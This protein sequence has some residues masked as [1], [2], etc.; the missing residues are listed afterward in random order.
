MSPIEKC[1]CHPSNVRI[2]TSSSGVF[3]TTLVDTKKIERLIDDKDTNAK[4]TR[5]EKVRDMHLGVRVGNWC[6]LCDF[7]TGCLSH[8][9]QFMAM[10]NG[11]S[12]CVGHVMCDRAQLYPYLLSRLVIF[13]CVFSREWT[14]SILESSCIQDK[15]HVIF[16][17]IDNMKD[18]RS[19]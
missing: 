14:C 2:T 10:G 16:L 8:G 15:N 12:C 11:G 19:Y 13:T 5:N 17:G 3:R 1:S 4:R 6:S 9:E 18:A 7:I